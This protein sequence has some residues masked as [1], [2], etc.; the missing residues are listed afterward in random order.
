MR[1]RFASRMASQTFHLIAT[2]PAFENVELPMTIL[3]KLSK[4][5]SHPR[6]RLGSPHPHLH[7]DWARPT[8]I[9]TRT[10]LTLPAS[11]PG[12]PV[13]PMAVS[14]AYLSTVL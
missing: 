7:R 2:M 4:K 6:H 5:V 11:A 12:T 3:G 1:K 13:V 8:H 10:R 9:Y 14:T